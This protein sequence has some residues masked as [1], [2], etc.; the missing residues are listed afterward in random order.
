[1]QSQAGHK[2]PTGYPARRVVLQLR[3]ESQDGAAIFVSGSFDSRGRLLG[4]DGT[5]LA[6]EAAGGPQQPHHQRIT[7]A[8]Q[9]QIYEAVLADTAGKP[10]YRLLRASSYAK[11]NRL[12]PVGWDPN[13]AE[14]ADIAP[15]GL[16]GDTNFVAG[17]DRLL[18]DVTLPAG[19]RGPLTVKATLYYQPLSPRHAAELMQTRVPEVLVLE[20][21]LATSGYRPETIADAKQVVP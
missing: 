2:L 14:I 11:D 15:A 20:R 17:K 7:S 9:V 1:M 8:D 16:G 19:Q 10:T 3:V 5:Q 13:D 6:S 18:Y 12:L 21:M 4:A